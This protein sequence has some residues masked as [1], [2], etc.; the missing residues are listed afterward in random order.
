MENE[1]KKSKRFSVIAKAIEPGAGMIPASQQVIDTDPFG[2]LVKSK[3]V[4]EPPFD[5]F[6]LTTMLEMNSELL[7]CID[8]LEK[9]IDGFGHR[10]VSNINEEAEGIP[11]A[12]VAAARREK[13]RLVNFFLYAGMDISFRQLRM[14]TRRDV[15]ATGNG[16]WEV[17]R[18]LEGKIQYFV[19]MRSYQMRITP[20]EQ[21]PFQYNMSIVELQDDESLK[22]ITI[23]RAKRFRRY[24]QIASSVYSSKVTSGYNTRWFK[25]FGDPRVYDI[26]TGREIIGDELNTFPMGKRANE[27]I[28]FGHYSP[29]SPYGV[30]RFIGALID[31]M[32]DRK[33]SEINY[34]TFCNNTVP[35]LAITVSNGEL[36]QGTVQRIQEFLEKIQGDDN[37]SKVLVIEAEPL[38]E[39]GE[40]TGQ[41]KID[42]KP[43][44]ESQIHDAMYKEYSAANKEKVR[45]AFRLP[46][47]FLGRSN[48]Y[49]RATSDT[50]RKLADEQIFA[51]ERDEFDDFVNRILFPEMGVVYHS[52]KSNSPNTT[53]NAELVQILSSAEKTGGMTPR[54][55]DLVL[56]DILGRDLPGFSKDPRFNMDLPF[57]L[58][59]ADAV[60]NQADVTE[61]G[62]QV[63]AVKR[64][65]TISNITGGASGGS[66]VAQTLLAIRGEL[67]RQWSE[68]TKVP[69]HHD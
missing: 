19:H 65:E 43:L 64:L 68:L 67:E 47:I 56:R 33:A 11:A 8:T 36:T 2:Q 37:R 24:V 58:S 45:V 32:G 10:L 49:N 62:Q 17:I 44:T 63:T 14:N 53:D 38:G 69:E 23:K 25:E 39:E 26:E 9:N 66:D 50:S 12:L 18:N 41:V 59:M 29:R 22:V 60:K 31:M 6:T 55:A 21:E 1:S 28:H 57:S 48:E 5:P 54:R 51:P 52:F 35:S 40:Q 61:P 27:V 34:V 13:V 46:P 42:I 20:L 15:E 16:Y 30:P 7:P 4:I 3:Q